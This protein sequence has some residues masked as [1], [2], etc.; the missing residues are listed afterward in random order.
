MSE[1]LS[2]SK[3]GWR[4]STTVPTPR[5]GKGFEIPR[6]NMATPRHQIRRDGRIRKEGGRLELIDERGRTPASLGAAGSG[7]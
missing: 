6:S 1:Y 5:T 7:A 3:K 4:E 2:S